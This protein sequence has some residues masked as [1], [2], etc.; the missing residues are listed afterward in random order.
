MAG[1]KGRDVLLKIHDGAGF[2]TIAGLRAK[3]IS[4]NARTVDAT[5][6][7]SASAWR[8]LIAGAGVKSATV[9]GAGVF[10]DAASDAE[11]R[12]AFFAQEARAW[13]VIVPDFGALE[14]PFLIEALDY[15]GDHDGEA[16]FAVTLASAGA[17]AFAA[18]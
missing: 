5:S 15:T 18:A 13:Q 10:K 6:A 9:S 16:A 12:E 1:Q 7:E 2:V 3:T 11:M 8:E 14:G 17:I 4:L